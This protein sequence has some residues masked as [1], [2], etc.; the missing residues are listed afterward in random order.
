M[1]RNRRNDSALRVGPV[2][3][4]VTLCALFAGLGVG[5]V[6]YKDQISI[7]GR[8]VREDE[9]TLAMLQRENTTRREQLGT[10][11]SSLALEQSVKKLNLGLGP[12]ALSQ[13]VRLIDAPNFAPALQPLTAPT[14]SP[15]VKMAMAAQHN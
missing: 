2:L 8:Q 12:P 5:Y 11:S 6:W 10:L 14:G 9:Q 15:Q 1:A 7:L 13:I 3:L 4:A